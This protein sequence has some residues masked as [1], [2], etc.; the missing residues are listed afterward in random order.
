MKIPFAFALLAL[1]AICAINA[2]PDT[3]LTPAELVAKHL[4]SIGSADAR[5]RMNGTRIKGD[6]TVSVKLCGEGVVEGQVL[7]GSHGSKSLIDM[8][9]DTPAY[10]Y[11]YMR[12]DGKD[13][14]VS[15]FRPGARTC[16]AQ[17]FVGHDVI[18][19]EGLAGGA[20]SESW[21]LRNLSERNPKL[22][23][24]GLKKVGDKQ[25]H[26]LKYNPRKG[27][28]LKIVLY[29]EPET[30]R[31]VR[32][33]YNRVIYASEQRRITGG[34][35]QLPSVQSQQ[36]SAA[37][38]EAHEEFSDFKEEAGLSLPH[39]YKFQLSVQSELR[40]AL[41]DWTLNLKE[42]KFDAPLEPSDFTLGNRP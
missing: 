15:N 30:F 38:I 9:F 7:I 37:R 42:F 16:L 4:E 41:I 13:F 17:F 35:G 10:P 5:A 6:A 21:A 28:D 14:A 33:D 29:F 12:F 27:S 39:T 11:E 19:K 8:T 32:T 31:H 36:A 1:T 22:E 3:K 24:A 20:L 2:N 18:F 26:A 25:L 23:Y 40:P 34:A